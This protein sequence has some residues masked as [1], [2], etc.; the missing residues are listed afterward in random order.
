M[1]GEEGA[2]WGSP[3]LGL[4]ITLRP[5][6]A[7]DLGSSCVSVC[8]PGVLSEVYDPV[9]GYGSQ[10]HEPRQGR[11]AATVVCFALP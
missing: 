4:C 7:G 9:R 1:R 5:D 6:V 10:T 11:N 3:V 2:G 8:L